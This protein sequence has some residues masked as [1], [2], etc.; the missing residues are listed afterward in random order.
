MIDNTKIIAEKVAARFKRYDVYNFPR[1]G[2]FNP[3]AF[4]QSYQGKKDEFGRRQREH[5]IGLESPMGQTLLAEHHITEALNKITHY[6]GRWYLNGEKSDFDTAQDACR[7]IKHIE[8]AIFERLS[9]AIVGLDALDP[10]NTVRAIYTPLKNSLNDS[11]QVV[12]LRHSEGKG[13]YAKRLKE[14]API[15]KQYLESVK[16]LCETLKTECFETQQIAAIS[17]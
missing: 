10:Q 16:S 2:Q 7:I 6:L 17:N 3:Q 14:Y 13:K 5:E 1:S 8:S 9:P 4:F 11:I 12:D 15:A